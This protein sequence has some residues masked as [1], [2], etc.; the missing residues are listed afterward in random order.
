VTGP[1]P[2]EEARVGDPDSQTAA[3]DLEACLEPGRFL[4]SGAATVI[5]YA[6]RVVDG[7]GE[8]V[9][10]AR[11]LYLAVRDDIRYDPYR[12]GRRPEE[13]S[14]SVA[15]ERGSGYCV[16]KAALLAASARAVGIPARLG[17]ADVRNHLTSDRLR[18]TLG[19]DLMVF[20]G[21]TELHL[22]G[23]W[24]KATPAFNRELCEKVGVAPLEFD[25]E[26]D[27]L[28]Q[29]LDLEGRRHLDYVRDRG[30]R[31]DVPLDEMWAA[32]REVYGAVRVRAMATGDGDWRDFEREAHT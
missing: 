24:V 3:D 12:I 13:H 30:V 17:F 7:A 22:R 31:L 14:A 1:P 32:W 5:A 4:D 28:F 29:P 26:H 9:E 8:P 25:G 2:S 6:R 15:L 11:R 16:P 27:S 18:R 23:R 10:R 21:Y 20:H 19:T